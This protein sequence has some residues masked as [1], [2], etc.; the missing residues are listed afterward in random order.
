MNTELRKRWTWGI[1]LAVFV[2]VTM[3]LLGPE[4]SF[5]VAI[6]CG[7]QA[8]RE[9][10]R[11]MNL[12][13]RPSLVWTGYIYV[14]LIFTHDFFVGS[15]TVF[16]LWLV[17]LSGFV[18]MFM[19]YINDRKRLGA[20]APEFDIQKS[21]TH[22]CRFILGVFYVHM[23]FGFIGPILSKVHGEY[24]VTLT[25]AT[26]F[27]SDTAAY[28]VGKSR[29]KRKLWPEL[30]PGKTI[31]GALAGWAAGAVMSVLVWALFRWVFKAQLPFS[32]VILVGICAG[33]FSQ[34]GDFLESLLK[35]VAGRKD[36][37]TLLPGHGGLLDRTDGLVFMMPLVYFLF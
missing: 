4:A 31:E 32:A 11:L 15:K 19:D 36:S 34:A 6:A 5:L 28:F 9:Y 12:N 29:G 14:G 16:W 17:W 24:I 22:L 8:W 23:L 27:S 18:I 1:A 30:S 37:G 35:R 25:F 3:F 20:R 10:C 13:E 33:P 26:V 21:W 2:L 7:L